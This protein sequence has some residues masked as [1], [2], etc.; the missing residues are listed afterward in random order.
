MYAGTDMSE[1][2]RRAKPGNRRTVARKKP[3]QARSQQTVTAIL[4][5]AARVFAE[6][7]YASTTTNHIAECAGVSI[8]SLY[9]YFPSK[10]AVLVALAERHVEHTFA[11][12]L[13]EVRSKREAPV[14][15]LLRALVDALVRAHQIEPRLH[16]VL[17]E[18]AHVI[19]SEFS[20]RLEELDRKAIQ[21]A[22]D[23]IEERCAELA[24]E[25]PEMASFIV[26]QVLEG[27][28]HA[29]VVRHPNVLGTAAFGDELV[30]LLHAYLMGGSPLASASRAAS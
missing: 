18:E 3:L 8:G 22:R 14:P 21:L 11:A 24:I 4:D 15:E 20:R 6:R 2:Q 26:V 9:Q 28:T 23:L 30:R 27:L 13:E 5:A 25:N 7:G 29:V 1:R 12:I 17:F 19:D 10:D 16:R